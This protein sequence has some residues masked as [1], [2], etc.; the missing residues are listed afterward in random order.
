MS[1]KKVLIVGAGTMGQ[2]IDFQ[3][4]RHGFDTVIFNRRFNFI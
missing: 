1:I 4:A 3:C 2:Q